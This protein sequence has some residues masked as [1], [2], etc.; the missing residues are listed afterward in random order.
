MNR[1]GNTEN[2]HLCEFIST[3][4]EKYK[5]HTMVITISTVYFYFSLTTPRFS[6]NMNAS[7]EILVLFS[8]PSALQ[9]DAKHMV[10]TF[11][12]EYSRTE[13][14]TNAEDEAGTSADKAVEGDI[15]GTSTEKNMEEEKAMGAEAMQLDCEQILSQL[16]QFGRKAPR[17]PRVPVEAVPQSPPSPPDSDKSTESMRSASSERS[18][19]SRTDFDDSDYDPEQDT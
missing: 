2:S 4:G 12:K 6:C 19:M 11:Q 14:A 7:H 15:L 17:T 9:L 16:P 1:R 3:E 5:L 10:E 13:E 18:S 8:Y